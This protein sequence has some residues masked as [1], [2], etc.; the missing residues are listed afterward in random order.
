MDGNYGN[1][2]FAFKRCITLGGTSQGKENAMQSSIQRG[3]TVFF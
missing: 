3:Q 2:N 1:V